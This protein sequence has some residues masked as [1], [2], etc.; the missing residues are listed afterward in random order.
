VNKKNILIATLGNWENLPEILGFTNPSIIPIYHHHPKKREID[1][2]RQKH[3]IEEVTEFW[4]LS[5]SN[6][7]N[8]SLICEWGNR[9]RPNINLRIFTLDNIEDFIDAKDVR[10]FADLVHRVLV[11]AVREKGEGKLYLSLAGGRKTMSSDLQQAAAFFG[12]DAMFHL[13]A[14]APYPS[15][16]IEETFRNDLSPEKT[17]NILP[18]I[19]AKFSPNPLGSTILRDIEKYP[20]QSKGNSQLEI[21]ENSTDLIDT[22]DRLSR[23]A[24]HFSSNFLNE[25]EAS[26][27]RALYALPAHLIHSLKTQEICQTEEDYQWMRILPKAELHCHLGGVLSAEE[28][29]KVATELQSELNEIKRTNG[30]FR[31]W[32][33]KL[34]DEIRTHRLDIKNL[35]NAVPNVSEPFCIAEFILKF[36]NTPDLL[37]KMIFGDYTDEKTYT[38]I[39]IKA[40]EKLGDLQGSAILQHEKTIQKTVEILAENCIKHNIKYLELRCSPA[41]YTRAGIRKEKVLQIIS[42]SLQKY[43]DRFKSG[44]ILI[45]SRHGSEKEIQE[46]IELALNYLNHKK[47]QIPIVGFDLAGDESARNPQQLFPLFLPVLQKCLHI[48]IHAGETAPADN[49]WKAVYQLS[50]ER[51]GHGLTLKEKPELISKFLDRHITLEMCPSSNQ[52]IVGYHKNYPLREYLDLG[53]KVTINTDNPGISRTD[54]TREYLVASKLC[55]N[56]LNRW[57]ILQIIKNSF[58]AGFIGFKERQKL[59]LEAEAEIFSLLNEKK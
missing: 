9:L 11:H 45:A 12:T 21:I 54:F 35:R 32:S 27:F 55:K 29:V 23:Q 53:L 39:G 2:S 51:I 38:K 33:E 22:I 34:D 6:P 18:I 7:K 50:A 47:L 10:Y 48:T 8:I 44:I 37:D 14:V 36:K 59:I 41:K 40:Y 28:I 30:Q 5:S 4:I 24:V 52:Q 31:E 43:A 3:Q 20:L 49:I 57:E 25:A 17:A 42:E 1:E 46:H 58:K 19:S 56:P 15:L 26:N 16:T 13:L